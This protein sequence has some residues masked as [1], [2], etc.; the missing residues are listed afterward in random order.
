MRSRLQVLEL[1]NIG[2]P[3]SLVLGIQEYLGMA[4]EINEMIC[5]AVSNL[6][7]HTLWVHNTC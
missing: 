4:R 1:F 3:V 7:L 6:D 5:A 2:D